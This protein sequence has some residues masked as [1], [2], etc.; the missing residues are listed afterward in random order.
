ML[1]ALR[2]R[3]GHQGKQAEVLLDMRGV[4]YG[5]CVQEQLMYRGQGKQFVLMALR[6]GPK[7]R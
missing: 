4:K 7:T 5:G 1:L 6:E 3:A 2:K